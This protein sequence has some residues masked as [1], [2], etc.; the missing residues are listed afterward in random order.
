MSAA[1]LNHSSVVFSDPVEAEVDS[2]AEE[3]IDEL[4]S[5]SETGAPPPRV[6]PPQV[7]AAPSDRESTTSPE[8]TGKNGRSGGTRLPGHSLL[9]AV[10]L[11]NIIQ[12]DGA[13]LALFF[14]LIDCS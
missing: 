14:A 1:F 7:K 2:Q 10:R 12:A 6:Q 9:P 11:E 8:P 13:R 4:D 3:E 5:D